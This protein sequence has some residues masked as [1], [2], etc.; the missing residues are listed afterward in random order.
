MED[1]IQEVFLAAAAGLSSFRHDRPGDTFRGWLRTIAHHEVLKYR[2]K[3]R[4]KPRAAGGSDAWQ[5]LERVAD[6]PMAAQES[7]SEEISLLYRRAVEQ[8]RSQFE[9]RT[10]RAFWLC[11]IEDRLTES[12]AQELGVTEAAVRQAKSRVLRRLRQELGDVLL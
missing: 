12:V 4:G 11:A 1:V 3:N 2:R 5:Q 8:V 9:E 6:A 10:W 7:D